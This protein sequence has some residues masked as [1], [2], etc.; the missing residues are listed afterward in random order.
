MPRWRRPPFPLAILATG[1]ASG[2]PRRLAASREPGLKLDGSDRYLDGSEVAMAP[3]AQP[4]TVVDRHPLLSRP[5]DWYE[6]TNGNKFKR[7]AVAAVVGVPSGIGG[8]IRQIVVG[9]PPAQ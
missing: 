2:Q 4:S 6:S 7:T 3:V 5:R 1:C 8:E 9:R